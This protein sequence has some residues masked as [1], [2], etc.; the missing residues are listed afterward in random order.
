MERFT[1]ALDI[2]FSVLGNFQ[3]CVGGSRITPA[4]REMRLLAVLVLHGPSPRSY[5]SGILWPET[6]QERASASL[7]AATYQIRRSVPG[8]LDLRRSSIGLARGVCT[9]LQLL[10]EC[11]AAGPEFSDPYRALGL[12]SGGELLAGWRDDWVLHE[13]ERLRHRRLRALAGLAEHCLSMGDPG[14]AL[15]AARSAGWLE[16]LGERSHVLAV[17]AMRR[18]GRHDEAEALRGQF[19]D[20]LRRELGVSPSPDLVR[21][22]AVG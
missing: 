3:L 10:R 17:R 7:R 1:S 15:A 9:D 12:L 2:E 14:T 20:R 19:I 22:L 5:I 8:M 6:T 11:L 21:L 4:T 16:P 13:R 18:M